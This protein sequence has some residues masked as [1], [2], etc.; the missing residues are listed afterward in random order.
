MAE[1]STYRVGPP[2]A[3][4]ASPFGALGGLIIFAGL[5][6][7]LMGISEYYGGASTGS[8][9]SGTVLEHNADVN[10]IVSNAMSAGLNKIGLGCVALL[11][12]GVFV[13]AAKK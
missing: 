1:P 2:P 13:A 8:M 11:L 3:P 7:L 6:L 9:Y 12:G 5:W 10:Q 4:K